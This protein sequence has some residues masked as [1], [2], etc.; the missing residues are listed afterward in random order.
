VTPTR[1]T[2]NY[3]IH[4][5]HCWNLAVIVRAHQPGQTKPMFAYDLWVQVIYMEILFKL[6]E[7][8]QGLYNEVVDS[9][10]VERKP[11]DS[12]AFAAVCHWGRSLN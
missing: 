11:E 6:L 9:I 5:D 10:C 3:V 12:L 8:K 2:A 1:Y 4:F 7:Q